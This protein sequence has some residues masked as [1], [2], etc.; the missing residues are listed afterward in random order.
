MTLQFGNYSNYVG[1]HYWNFLDELFGRKSLE[2][3][4]S[5]C[6]HE[7]FEFQKL[8]RS[9]G[10]RGRVVNYP[11]VMMF[12]HAGQVG[13]LHPEAMQNATKPID[14]RLHGTFGSVDGAM[15]IGEGALSHWNGDVKVVKSQPIRTNNF[16]Q[17][18][19][20]NGFNVGDSREGGE[21][22]GDRVG[23]GGGEEE[24]GEEEY[25][26]DPSDVNSWTNFLQA[27][28]NHDSLVELPTF[29]SGDL[30][31][32]DTFFSGTSEEII[33]KYLRED[34]TDK[35]R[36]L[37]E[38]CDRVTC[39]NVMADVHDGFSGL[40]ASF[41]DEIRDEV[42]RA[43]MPVW[44]FT[45][46]LHGKG[47]IAC[48]SVDPIMGPYYGALSLRS[49]NIS[50]FYSKIKEVANFI[51][52]IDP[53]GTANIAPFSI[54]SDGTF[55]HTAALVAAAIDTLMSPNYFKNVEDNKD[56]MSLLGGASMNGKYKF[57]ETEISFPA[58]LFGQYDINNDISK[59]VL[60]CF[61]SSLSSAACGSWASTSR[62]EEMTKVYD[63]GFSTRGIEKDLFRMKC[64]EVQTQSQAQ[65]RI[66]DFSPEHA[67]S[68]FNASSISTPM[69]IP[70]SYPDFFYSN[71]KDRRQKMARP[72]DSCS[73]VAC[74]RSSYMSEHL[75]KVLRNWNAC[76]KA[77]S[78]Q[79]SQLEKV[80]MPIEECLEI[81][82]SLE[83]IISTATDV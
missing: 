10:E 49:C 17:Y 23:G 47:D 21:E 22:E 82:E 42:P 43:F 2:D 65:I 79:S 24:E 74:G 56:M 52:P 32:F 40:A 54:T 1:A 18:L 67:Y 59:G 8:Y 7:R 61:T 58:D 78:S 31:P 6:A 55:Y 35:F 45:D 48:K 72:L 29:A 68:R 30:E 20:A 41:L 76:T 80:G 66:R 28:V 5:P 37:L 64:L 16:F 36:C 71:A 19:D 57:I 46:P 34:Y 63:I 62:S 69:P 77:N 11:R 27:K 50:L 39:I 44:A 4:E 53:S 83:Q 38:E 60:T 9:R 12:D 73:I 70:V 25:V 33:N 75:T 51:L 3:S 13:Y 81:S 15:G 14:Q 26:I